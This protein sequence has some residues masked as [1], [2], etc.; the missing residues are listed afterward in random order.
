M[1]TRF[2]KALLLACAIVLLSSVPAS[3]APPRPDRVQNAINAY[4][5]NVSNGSAFNRGP[6]AG[7]GR[8]AARAR[9]AM[10]RWCAANA[11]QTTPPAVVDTDGDGVAD[12]ADN[13]PLTANA[14]QADANGDGLGDACSDS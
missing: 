9:A 12:P 5:A 13:C 3:A 11:T 8:F 4:C 6:F 14:D 10:V 7:R 2:T 1:T